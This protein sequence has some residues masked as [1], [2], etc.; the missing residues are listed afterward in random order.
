MS[1]TVLRAI[2]ALVFAF[3]GVGHAMGI[4]PA[5]GVAG[6]KGA[7][8]DWL[9]NWSSRSWLLTDLLGD[10]VSRVVC[11][12]LYGLA[13][14]GFVGAALGLLGWGIPHAWWRTLATV[15]AVISLLALA[16]FW[17]ALIF[18]FP[19]KVGALAINVATLVC[20]LALNWP[21]V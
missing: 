3:H 9:R 11:V 10:P 2:V 4:I 17:N 15:S 12:A 7:G 8:R 6:G 1:A 21:A 14:V 20:L 16:L 13:L 18:L 19:H 5:L